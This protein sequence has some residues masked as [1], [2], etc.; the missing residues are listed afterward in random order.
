MCITAYEIIRERKKSCKISVQND[1]K[2]RSHEEMTNKQKK[3][4][5]SPINSTVLTIEHFDVLKKFIEFIACYVVL[6]VCLQSM[7]I[8]VNCRLVSS[9][10]LDRTFTNS[11]IY[12]CLWLTK[13]LK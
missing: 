11:I 13:F 1:N 3:K 9:Y 6:M 12:L 4:Q 2:K 10:F 5:Q 8:L 7:L